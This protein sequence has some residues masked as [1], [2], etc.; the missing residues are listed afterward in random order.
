LSKKERFRKSREGEFHKKRVSEK[1]ELLRQIIN[2]EYEEETEEE[3]KKKEK[4]S[5]EETTKSYIISYIIHLDSLI[6]I[7]N[8]LAPKRANTVVY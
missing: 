2:L 5:I 8:Y 7:G 1:Y 4:Y 6:P 3:R